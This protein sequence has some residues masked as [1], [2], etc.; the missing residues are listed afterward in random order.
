MTTI[1]I[2]DNLINELIAVSHYQNAQEAVIKVLSDYLQQHKNK[3]SFF[4]QLRLVDDYTDDE[5]VLLFERDKDT[6]RNIEL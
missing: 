5:M 1:T 2:D 3:Q 4:E 6:G